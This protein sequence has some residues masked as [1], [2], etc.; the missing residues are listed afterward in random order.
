MNNNYNKEKW[1]RIMLFN[2]D[3]AKYAHE[4]YERRIAAFRLERKLRKAYIADSPK[5]GFAVW[6]AHLLS[7]L[8]VF[9][10]WLARPRTPVSRTPKASSVGR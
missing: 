1:S 6:R 5:P 4:E 3:H 2:F 10:T 8:T 9:A 7:G